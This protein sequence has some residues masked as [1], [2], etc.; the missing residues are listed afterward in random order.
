MRG[1]HTERSRLTESPSHRLA[2][3][4][5]P[6]D[7]GAG[8]T[9]CAPTNGAD[10]VGRDDLGAPYLPPGGKVARRAG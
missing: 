6:F 7:K 2:A 9:L 5:A 3:A 8:R 4:T 1:R 10:R